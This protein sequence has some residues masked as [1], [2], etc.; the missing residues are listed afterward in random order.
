MLPID[1]ERAHLAKAELDIV[2][3]QARI[4]RQIELLERL[5]PT[6]QDLSQAQALLE[7]LQQTLQTWRD[8]RDEILRTIARLEH[9]A[10]QSS[11]SNMQS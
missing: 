1:M 11:T 2:E 10:A 8:H 4:D 6:G 3:G 7:V 9:A 5:R